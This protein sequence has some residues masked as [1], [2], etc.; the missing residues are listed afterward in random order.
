M[1]E[2]AR[3][4][5]AGVVVGQRDAPGLA[6]A[7]ADTLE[8][9]GSHEERLQVRKRIRDWMGPEVVARQHLEVYRVLVEK[10]IRPLSSLT[11]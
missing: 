7:I 9:P 11:D 6:G 8:R 10:P 3:R 4:I 2:N 5:R 1:A